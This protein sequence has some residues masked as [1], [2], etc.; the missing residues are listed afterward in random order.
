MDRAASRSVRISLE[1]S[2]AAAFAAVSELG[3]GLGM[4]RGRILIASWV[5]P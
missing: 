1:A 2:L 4:T 5:G 3:L